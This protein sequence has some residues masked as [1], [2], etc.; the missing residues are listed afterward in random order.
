VRKVPRH[1]RAQAGAAVEEGIPRCW[2][3]TPQQLARS[4]DD[5][6]PF[7]IRFGQDLPTENESDQFLRDV[8][9]IADLCLPCVEALEDE[10][11]DDECHEALDYPNVAMFP[12]NLQFNY[13]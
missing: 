4:P 1:V 3:E 5:P 7:I 9:D 8:S 2:S 10:V 6:D 12:F 11:G 13:L